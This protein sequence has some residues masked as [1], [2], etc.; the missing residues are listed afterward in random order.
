MSEDTNVIFIF[1]NISSVDFN[2]SPWWFLF[3]FVSD[4]E[5]TYLW[6]K[7][8]FKMENSITNPRLSTLTSPISALFLDIW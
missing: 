1:Y 5:E 6:L 7:L 8:F 3:C 2:N 4:T